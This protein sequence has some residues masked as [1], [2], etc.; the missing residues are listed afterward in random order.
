MSSTGGGGGPSADPPIKL[1]KVMSITDTSAYII[2]T[3]IGSGIFISP[4]GVLQNAG[5]PGMALVMWLVTG[6]I[7][8]VQAF[9]Y[10]E[11]SLT[12]PEAGSDYTYVRRI[13]GDMV[14]HLCKTTLKYLL[15]DFLIRCLFQF[16][17]LFIWVNYLIRDSASRGVVSLTFSTYF[18]QMFFVGCQPPESLK[19]VVAA[20]ALSILTA[21]QCYSSKWAVKTADFFTVAKLLG[22]VV[23]VVCGWGYLVAG[24]TGNLDGF[25]VGSSPNVGDYVT[26]FYV[27]NWA[28]GGINN[29]NY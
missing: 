14:R 10:A 13:F 11:L 26:A 7:S 1:R 9:C 27:A 23:I 2:C 25:M 4:K 12:F 16:A 8:A 21:V 6:V 19:R 3:V 20:M 18:C 24:N 28:Y 15:W 22:L 29:G 5:S 17:F